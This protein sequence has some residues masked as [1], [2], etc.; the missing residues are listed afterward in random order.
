[1]SDMNAVRP[2]SLKLPDGFFSMSEKEQRKW[3]AEYLK[4]SVGRD[5]ALAPDKNQEK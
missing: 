2:L 3:V 1:M 4:R 5:Y